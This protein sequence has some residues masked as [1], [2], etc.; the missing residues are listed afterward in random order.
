M[1]GDGVVHQACRARFDVRNVDQ[2]QEGICASGG[3]TSPDATTARASSRKVNPMP[4]DLLPYG[5][6]LLLAILVAGIGALYRRHLYG[7]LNPALSVGVF[8]LGLL[9]IGGAVGYKK[10]LLERAGVS[11]PIEYCSDIYCGYQGSDLLFFVAT[12]ALFYFF[13]RDK[14]L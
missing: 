10:A 6:S 5:L 8:A 7:R 12:V 9:L 4:A 11:D 14:K 1:A 13:S 3:L 2:S